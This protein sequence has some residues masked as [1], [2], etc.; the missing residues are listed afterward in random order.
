MTARLLAKKDEALLL[1]YCFINLA[2]VKF[3]KKI[4][5]FLLY[6]FE[7]DPVI[8]NVFLIWIGLALLLITV[9]F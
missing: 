4:L 7:S 9:S 6:S 2:L 3:F 8:L 5:Q 1:D